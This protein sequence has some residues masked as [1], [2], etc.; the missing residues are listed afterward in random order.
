MAVI[1][2][3]R[4]IGSLGDEVAKSVSKNLGY[5]L[6]EKS[7]ISAFLLE[8]GFSPSEIDQYDETNPSLLQHLSMQ[9]KVFNHAIR[10]AIYELAVKNNVVIVGRGAQVVLKD[11]PGTFNIRVIAPY[12][13]RIER[14]MEQTGNERKKVQYEIQQSD[15]NSSGYVHTYFNVNWDDNECYDL[16]LNTQKMTCNTCAEMITRA[17]VGD[18]F[19]RSPQVTET[20]IDLALTQKVKAFLLEFDEVAEYDLVVR[21]RRVCLSE[22]GLPLPDDVKD[23]CKKALSNIKQLV[24]IE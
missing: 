19:R 5:E 18:E 6:I 15:R 20:L 2:I 7:Q 8:H 11:I 1:T 13:A 9:K 17:V 10:A 22:S 4:Q 14:L 12:A 24:E 16:I 23:V 21:N 3:S